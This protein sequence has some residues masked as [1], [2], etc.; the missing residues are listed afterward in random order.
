MGTK[1]VITYYMYNRDIIKCIQ[2]FNKKYKVKIPSRT[3][4]GIGTGSDQ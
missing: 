1:I 2:K 4:I 3:D